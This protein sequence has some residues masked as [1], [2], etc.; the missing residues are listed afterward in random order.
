M[1][2]WR[3]LTN[4]DYL[5]SYS[6]EDGKDII[7]TIDRVQVETV[8][9]AEGKREDCLV[10]HWREKAKPMI[11]NSTNAKM[12][13]KLLKTPYIEQWSGHS[14][15][16]GVETVRAFGEIV[17]A[18]RVRSFLPKAV[19]VKCEACGNDIQGA[20]GMDSGQLADYTRHKYGRAL[21]AS[22][23]TKEAQNA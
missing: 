10:C 6:L 19:A 7:L 16:I 20:H 2:H 22:C 5:G 1:T 12:I 15:Q 21:C 17:D 4:P 11:L 8:T 23:A 3:K 13:Q 18:L 9:G 14:V